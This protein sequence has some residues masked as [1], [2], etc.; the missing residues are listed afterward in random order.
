MARFS[1]ILA[2]DDG[3][4]DLE[5]VFSKG[6]EDRTRL[7]GNLSTIVT[8]ICQNCLK[9]FGFILECP[10]DLEIV[11]NES[12]MAGVAEG[13]DAIVAV[14]SEIKLA[15]VLED[16]LIMSVPMIPR[17]PEFSCPDND[18]E[19]KDIKDLFG[20]K[21]TIHRPFADLAAAIKQKDTK[22]S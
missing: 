16:E 7:H 10:I 19:Q 1:E 15:E 11:S 4:I 21:S 3:D 14:D 17:H 9:P 12:E 2:E 18:Y 5:L 6:K 22:E 13:I 20:S 8:L